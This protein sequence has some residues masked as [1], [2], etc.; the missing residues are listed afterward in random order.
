M[1]TRFIC[2]FKER[3]DRRATKEDR[4]EDRVQRCEENER[5]ERGGKKVDQF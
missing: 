2:Y 5:R 1:I 4:E 3:G